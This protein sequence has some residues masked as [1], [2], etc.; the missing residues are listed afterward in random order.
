MEML[1]PH[2]CL[3]KFYCQYERHSCADE[4]PLGGPIL[5]AM[6]FCMRGDWHHYAGVK[7]PINCLHAVGTDVTRALDIG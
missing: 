3:V 5:I 2:E 4:N 7:F 6:E 1:P